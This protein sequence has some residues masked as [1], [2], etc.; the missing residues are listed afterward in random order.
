MKNPNGTLL[1]II[2]SLGI[3]T[4]IL[5]GLKVY[6]IANLTLLQIFSPVLLFV[7]IFICLIIF[8]ESKP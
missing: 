6:G 1:R 8:L 2:I 7:A 5:A 3:I 4:I